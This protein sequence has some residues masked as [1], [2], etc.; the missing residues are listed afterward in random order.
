MFRFEDVIC[1]HESGRYGSPACHCDETR[2]HA[3]SRRR[4]HL[5][6]QSH[7]DYA[8]QREQHVGRMANVIHFI[9]LKFVHIEFARKNTESKFY[10]I[11]EI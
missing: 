2:H 10:K 5:Q 6:D 7:L 11:L 3:R 8:G 1:H 9:F 4:Q